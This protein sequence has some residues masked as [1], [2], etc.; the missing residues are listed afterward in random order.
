MVYTTF[1]LNAYEAVDVTRM[2]PPLPPL[3]HKED[4]SQWAQPVGS[5]QWQPE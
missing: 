2:M 4:D 1:K 3:F 5:A